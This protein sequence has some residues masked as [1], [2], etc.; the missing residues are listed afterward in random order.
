[1]ARMIAFPCTPSACDPSNLENPPTCLSMDAAAAA[2]A[3]DW[4][5]KHGSDF[6]PPQ[7]QSIILADRIGV[8][9][10]RTYIFAVF[11]LL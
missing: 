4:L 9:H 6:V 5:A 11:F 3:A 2:A 1:M 8:V 7:P 10:F